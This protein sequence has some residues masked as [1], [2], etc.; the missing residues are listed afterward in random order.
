[1]KL[2]KK[3]YYQLN[4]NFNENKKIRRELL[5]KI[6]KIDPQF[7]EAYAEISFEHSNDVQ[8]GATNDIEASKEKSLSYITKAMEIDSES[9]EVRA[10]YGWYYYCL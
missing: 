5:Q 3:R 8:F 6:I 2:I 10:A 4:Y 7:A 9:V 1:M